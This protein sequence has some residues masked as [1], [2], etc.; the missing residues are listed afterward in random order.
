MRG[1]K[2]AREERQRANRVQ[3][4]F[5]SY[6]DHTLGRLTDLGADEPMAIEAIFQTVKYLGDEGV[7][8][9]FPEGNVSYQTMGQWLVAAADFGLADF[10]VEAIQE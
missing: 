4:A 7:L 9:V 5:D 3:E 2:R 6:L 1:R 10:M 8:P